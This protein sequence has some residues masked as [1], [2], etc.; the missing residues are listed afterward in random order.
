MYLYPGCTSCRK[1]EAWLSERG[2][3]GGRAPCLERG[4]RGLDEVEGHGG[5][6]AGGAR[7][8]LSTGRGEYA[9]DEGR[10]RG[11]GRGDALPGRAAGPGEP[12]CC[13]GPDHDGGRAWPATIPT[14]AGSDVQQM[15]RPQPVIGWSRRSVKGGAGRDHADR[16]GGR[17]SGRCSLSETRV[18]SHRPA[19]LRPRGRLQ[20]LCVRLKFESDPGEN[21]RVLEQHGVKVIIDPVSAMFLEGARIDY[22]ENLM[23]GGFTIQ[24]PKLP[25]L[26][27]RPVLQDA[28]GTGTSPGLRRRRG[29]GAGNSRPEAGSDDGQAAPPGRRLVAGFR[30]QDWAGA[31]AAENTGVSHEPVARIPAADG[32][33]VGL[34]DVTR[35]RALAA[36]ADGP[37]IHMPMARTPRRSR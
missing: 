28:Q 8:L 35:D 23:G 29:L 11:A 37:V 16:R 18:R 30:L 32:R 19:R 34:P 13:A 7:D 26:R 9:G 33:L 12:R 20:R 15:Y 25:D 21:D 4:A 1:A 6:R 2:L 31:G 17:R 14:G 27:L 36:A 10:G 24:N 22:V 5:A 3:R